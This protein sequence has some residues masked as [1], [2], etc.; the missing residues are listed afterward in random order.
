MKAIVI[1]AGIIGVNTAY[2]LKKAGCK[3]SVIDKASG[4]ATGSTDA[5]GGILT[6]S[7]ADPWN[8][9]GV[10]K[11]LL[12]WVGKDD[13]PMLLRA[14]AIPGLIP[15]GIKFLLA[16][17]ANIFEK[18]CRANAELAVFSVKNFSETVKKHALLCS[19]QDSGT[20]K[21]YRNQ[22]ALTQGQ[23][24]IEQIYDLGVKYQ[25]LSKAEAIAKEPALTP[26][27]DAL[28]GALFFPNDKSAN[29]AEYTRSLLQVCEQNGVEFIWNT[30]VNRLNVSS[31]RITGVTHQHGT[32][33][34]DIVIVAGG[35]ESPL[36]S[37]TANINIPIKPVKGY[38]ISLPVNRIDENNVLPLPRIP[39]VDDELHSAVIPLGD[40]IR[41]AGTAEFSGFDREI[42]KA[43]IENLKSLTQQIL[44]M[45]ADKL[46]TNDCGAKYGF[47]PMCAD[48][49]PVIGETYIKGLYMNS[50]HG[51]L[52]LTLA[53]G[54]AKLLTQLI[55]NQKT[56]ISLDAFSPKRFIN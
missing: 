19:Y 9:P 11:D 25:V 30:E 53:S 16:S 28:V 32:L 1:G 21:I 6:P 42:V 36:V 26:I 10:W 38:S 45:H 12:R 24:K 37:K 27:S 56:D 18:N 23:Q 39:I 40:I 47:R 55:T 43:R 44:P 4:P 49:L 2:E 52:G 46:L 31:N 3:V 41:I 34:A 5:T 51:H 7:M 54:S 20:M 35:C 33:T 50:G 8:S 17:R 14:K 29:A 13:A 48:G 22:A 15:W